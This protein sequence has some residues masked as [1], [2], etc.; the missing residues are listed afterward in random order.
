MPKAVAPENYRKSLLC[1]APLTSLGAPGLAQ[2]AAAPRDPAA[3]ALHIRPR[4][5]RWDVNPGQEVDRE[6]S[7]LRLP[8]LGGPARQAACWSWSTL[9][10]AL[11]QGSRGPGGEDNSGEDPPVAG[12][13]SAWRP[14][15]YPLRRRPRRPSRS[16]VGLAEAR[17]A[18]G[19]RAGGARRPAVQVPLARCPCRP[20]STALDGDRPWLPLQFRGKTGPYRDFARP[21]EPMEECGLSG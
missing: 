7:G 19:G 17:S 16:R 11:H 5:D 18:A 12:R 9:G 14:A 8:G 15:G 6:E 4:Y 10:P 21:V 1:V 3:P 20:A 13:L 2:D